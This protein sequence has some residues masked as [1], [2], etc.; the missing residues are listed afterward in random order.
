MAEN[1]AGSCPNPDCA[2]RS[3]AEQD[4]AIAPARALLTSRA[5][6]W[7]STGVGKSGRSVEEVAEAVADLTGDVDDSLGDDSHDDLEVNGVHRSSPRYPARRVTWIWACLMAAWWKGLMVTA[8]AAST[9]R[10]LSASLS[11]SQRVLLP[12]RFSVLWSP[13]A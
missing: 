11:C 2:R 5:A 13:I 9:L 8:L 10:C 4:P 1:A 6:R 12:S 7:V 3:F